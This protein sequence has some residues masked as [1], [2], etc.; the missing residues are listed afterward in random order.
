MSLLLFIRTSSRLVRSTLLCGIAL[1]LAAPVV[2]QQQQ[3]QQ[4]AESQKKEL[5]QE[6]REQV[7]ALPGQADSAAEG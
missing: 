2:A 6:M 5:S 1:L 3:A 4:P 7:L